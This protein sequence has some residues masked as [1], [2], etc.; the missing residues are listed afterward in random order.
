[1]CQRT[2]TSIYVFRAQS[3]YTFSTGPKALAEL[4]SET[5]GRVFYDDDSE[6][7]IDN[8][9]RTIEANLRNQYRLVYSPAEPK[10]DGSFHRIE[11]KATSERVGNIVVRS[12]YY[13]TEH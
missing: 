5:G 13:A 8:N 11:L 12:G 7:V 2:N 9:L 10:P 6:V 4:A 1:M 3:K